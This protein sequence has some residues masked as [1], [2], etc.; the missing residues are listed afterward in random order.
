MPFD[1]WFTVDLTCFI[2]E[3]VHSLLL[4]MYVFPNLER[5]LVRN[6]TSIFAD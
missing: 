4:R 2:V 1:L 5:I 3:N 6:L